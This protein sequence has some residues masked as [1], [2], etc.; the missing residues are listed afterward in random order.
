MTNLPDNLYFGPEL[1]LEALPGAIFNDGR[2]LY[3]G[4]EH[5]WAYIGHIVTLRNLPRSP[6]TKYLTDPDEYTIAILNEPMAVYVDRCWFSLDNI[7]STVDTS[8]VMTQYM[9]QNYGAPNNDSITVRVEPA[10]SGSMRHCCVKLVY[11]DELGED[12]VME[13]YEHI[14]VGVEQEFIMSMLGCNSDIK[15]DYGDLGM[16]AHFVINTSTPP[17][18]GDIWVDND[19][20]QFMF[21]KT[22][23]W[24]SIGKLAFNYKGSFLTGIEVLSLAGPHKMGDAYFVDDFIYVYN[25]TIKRFAVIQCLPGNEDGPF[26]MYPPGGYVQPITFQGV[27]RRTTDALPNE[28]NGGGYV[29]IEPDGRH[30][31]YS[32][33]NYRIA[34]QLENP[35]IT[36]LDKRRSPMV[37]MGNEKYREMCYKWD[38]LEPEDGDVWLVDKRLLTFH[39]GDWQELPAGTLYSQRHS[40]LEAKVEELKETIKRRRELG[41]PDQ[42]DALA[43]ELFDSE[44]EA[45]TKNKATTTAREEEENPIR[46]FFKRLCSSKPR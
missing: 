15:Q 39:L 35:P 46:A 31:L 36:N 7:A 1:P 8:K 5:G 42:V 10:R 24:E 23:T 29:V 4:G 32:Q 28:P 14:P 18:L 19:F 22:K 34:S 13:K 17:K 45:V 16:S 38:G 12:H 26:Y 3:R 21:G 27:Y 43:Q 41:T 2:C 6:F 25:A 30:T 9:L 11:R 33:H 44:V 40:T 20:N 37:I